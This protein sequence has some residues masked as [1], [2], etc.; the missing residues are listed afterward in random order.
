MALAQLLA[1]F[2]IC[3]TGLDEE[4]R[5]K[6]NKNHQLTLY[7]YFYEGWCSEED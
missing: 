3:C 1:N 6:L 5:V 2:T 4:T 7:L